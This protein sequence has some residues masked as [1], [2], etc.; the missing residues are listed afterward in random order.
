VS[1]TLPK[2]KEAELIFRM[3]WRN[4]FRNK[5]RTMITTGSIFLAVFLALIMRSMQLGSYAH[6]IENV[7]HSYTGYIQIQKKGYW[8]E[9]DINHSFA[10]NDSLLNRISRIPGVTA[11]I[12][13]LESV[14]LASNG[15]KTKGAM[16][17]GI[18]PDVET[19]LT[20]VKNRV[21][22]GEY[23]QS[24]DK[25]ALVAEKIAKYLGLRIHDTLILI[26]EG[27][28]GVEAAGKFPVRG[29][30]HFNS[31][32]LNN[33]MILLTLPTCQDFFSAGDNVTSIALN[34]DKPDKTDYIAQKIKAGL[35]P[36]KYTV[37]KWYDMMAG[38]MNL[39]RADSAS[40]LIM[41]GILYMVISFGIFGAILMMTA[42]RIREF[43]IL[44]SIG[45]QKIR[46]SVMVLIES[47]L[48][49]AIGLLLGI[50]CSL[51]VIIYFHHFPISLTG[52]SAK[53]TEG[54]GFEALLSF[55]LPDT[56]FLNNT[57]LILGIMLLA[58][59]YP[60]RKIAVMKPVEAL[61]NKI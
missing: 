59:L 35:D 10:L 16:L 56:Y 53:S 61:R 15:P 25:G 3:A 48:I 14:A 28:H 41:L 32:D 1:K 5:R 12:P 43:G 36:Q 20:G 40:G 19:Q 46:L 42:E 17:V 24:Q 34:L 57:L 52:V 39:I 6:I 4:L 18:R 47:C 27:Y 23:L 21:V 7:V 50:I 58:S 26:G 13:R 30:V 38:I 22:A 55:Q 31:P 9:K 11:C 44:L 33:R 49:G 54:F 45:T 29:I 2:E 60:L 51:P 37:M 8:K